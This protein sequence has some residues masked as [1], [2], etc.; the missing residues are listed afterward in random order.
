M[1]LGHNKSQKSSGRISI[2][3]LIWILVLFLLI[4][5]AYKLT[6]PYVSY[7]MLKTDVKEELKLS[8]MY[9]DATLKKRIVKKA[10]AWSVPI[11]TDDLILSRDFDNITV[12]LR[13]SKTIIFFGRYKKKFVFN[14]KATTPVRDRNG[15]LR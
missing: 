4:Y 14:I 13:Y 2:K 9:S 5:S 3:A 10:H 1:R 8:Y 7:Y 12:R 11:T 15:T 6:Y